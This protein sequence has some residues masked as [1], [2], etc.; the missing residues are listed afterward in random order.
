[1]MKKI[2]FLLL[3]VAVAVAA[4]AA[5]AP[6]SGVVTT[7]AGQPGI[8]G[9][10]DGPSNDAMFT[11]PTWL[12]VA[13]G[14]SG[15]SCDLGKSGEIFV[16][17]R[18]NGLVRRISEN[19]EVS[20]MS[21]PAAPS[22]FGFSG[23]AFPLDFDSAFGG[24]ILVEPP[25]AGCGCGP[26]ARGFFVASTGRRQVVL[27]AMSWPFL[28]NR[29]QYPVVIGTGDPGARD[30][31]PFSEA[32]FRAPVGIARS[33]NGGND[34]NL[35]IQKQ[36]LYI[37]DSGNHTIRRV[38]F[39]LS[40][41][42]CPQPQTVTTL[43][44]AAGQPGIAD[45]V[46]SAA[47]FNT[48]RGI[49]ATDDGT[50]YVTDAGNHTVRRITPAGAVTTIAGVPGEP[51]SDDTHLN[52]PSG[53]DVN[54]KGEV[55]IVDTFNHAIRMIATD[56]K[57]ITV[58]GQLGVSGFADGDAATAKFNAPVGLKIAPDGSIV[59]ADTGNNVIRR[60]TLTR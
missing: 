56:G 19:G 39:T 43:A 9:Y 17:D 49:A 11:H 10:W 42:F 53:I 32:Q 35:S 26:Y 38:S 18:I 55:F 15:L 4:A 22:Y 21:V 13:V 50:L 54:D 33:A 8:A 44:G 51:G 37:A 20:T 52:T 5:A 41:E 2:L 1:M 47:R 25:W 46:G 7:V 3:F 14:P 31:M 12:D 30:G 23:T 40:F 59:I 60:L 29:D 58:A 34:P 16:V 27:A 48:P 57:L 28:A 36:A 45:G 24:G 6:P